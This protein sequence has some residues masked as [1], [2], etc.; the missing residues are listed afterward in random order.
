MDPR[1]LE[2][3]SWPFERLLLES[4]WATRLAYSLVGSDHA[5]DLLQ[6]TWLQALRTAPREV[7]RSARAWL[8]TLMRRRAQNHQRSERSRGD[9]LSRITNAKEQPSAGLLLEREEIRRELVDAVLELPEQAREVLV[10]R[11]FEELSPSL[12]AQ[13]LNLSPSTVRSR[14]QRASAELR[15]GL[16]VS[17]GDDWRAWC[18][19]AIP[20]NWRPA[21]SATGRA[22]VIGWTICVGVPLTVGGVWVATRPNLARQ[23]SE[24]AATLISHGESAPQ[25]RMRGSIPSS[26]SENDSPK[27][28]ATE[29]RSASQERASASPLYSLRGL[30]V[31]EDQVPLSGIRVTAIQLLNEPFALSDKDGQFDLPLTHLDPSP[32]PFALPVESTRITFTSAKYRGPAKDMA[33]HDKVEIDLGV[34]AC[35]S[36]PYSVSGTVLDSLG[37][38]EQNALVFLLEDFPPDAALESRLRTTIPM[39]NCLPIGKL[40]FVL[41]DQQGRFAVH[42]LPA[43]GWRVAIYSNRHDGLLTSALD[44]TGRYALDLGQLQ[45]VASPIPSSL[46]GQVLLPDGQPAAGVPVG[47]RADMNENVGSSLVPVVC[48]TDGR[49]CIPVPP[50]SVCKLSTTSILG[51][52]QLF[53]IAPGR[54]ELRLVLVPSDGPAAA[55]VSSPVASKMTRDEALR[56]DSETPCTASGIFRID[57]KPPRTSWKLDARVNHTLVNAGVI[58]SDGALRMGPLRSGTLRLQATSRGAY[59]QAFVRTMDLLPGRNDLNIDVTTG[60]L[61]LT[62]L[63]VPEDTQSADVPCAL[64]W[65]NDQGLDWTLHIRQAKGGE[66]TLAQVPVGTLKVHYAA[67]GMLGP[68]E[69]HPVVGEIRIRRGKETQYACPT[70]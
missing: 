53:D 67:D 61:R 37:E 16:K 70:R 14:L 36:A 2:S 41:T 6:E 3:E 30:C 42:S 12:I 4:A 8:G 27:L 68:V 7:L 28:V 50:G 48:D 24:E 43:R 60:S 55:R 66:L 34:I 23:G 40:G 51:R 56:L 19:G 18:M 65:S 21:Q 49:F 38:P 62:S 25:P 57:G 10:L 39:A 31:D 64:T 29:A 59:S 33:L 22:R 13:R 45:L 35:R 26:I 15:E 1:H 5:E 17:Q 54:A 47:G 32:G 20:A 52:A 58:S 63:P 69:D 44:F 46:R 9:R 11:Y